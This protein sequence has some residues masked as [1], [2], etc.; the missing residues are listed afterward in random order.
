M[1]KSENRLSRREVLGMA[2]GLGSWALSTSVFAQD[3]TRLFTPPLTLGPFYPQVKPLDQDADLTLIKGRTTRA[4]GQ[5]IHVAGRVLNLKGEAVKDA[6]IEIWQADSHG[7]YAHNSDKNPAQLDSGFQGYAVLQ[8][9]ND[10]RYRFKTIKPA[11]YPGLIAG[12]RTPHIHFE[13]FGKN[14]RLV[15]QMFFPD[16]PLNAQDNILQN[17]RPSHREGAIAKPLT[18]KEIAADELMFGWDIVL[19]SG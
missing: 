16:E 10:G 5:V 15:T 8:T 12:K 4:E 1:G 13:V 2:V 11:P 19:I 17:V 9:D 3:A 6:R 14:D 7:R 18:N